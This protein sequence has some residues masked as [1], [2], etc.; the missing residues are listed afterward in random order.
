MGK[1]FY[2]CGTYPACDY[3]VWDKPEPTPCPS[4][5]WPFITAK[6]SKKFGE[7]HRCPN[8]DWNDNKEAAD[9]A[10]MFR[11][12]FAKVREGK[13]AAKAAAKEKAAA[14]KKASKAAAKPATTKAAKPK[15][16]SKPKAKK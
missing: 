3:A 4:C 10:A 13:M 16:P 1:T 11:A 2:S 6:V 5:N 8:C 15:A 12:R 14:A 7:W 9:Q